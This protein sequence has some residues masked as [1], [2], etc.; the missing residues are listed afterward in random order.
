[1]NRFC[2]AVNLTLRIACVGDSL[3][4]GDGLHE[5]PPKHRVPWSGLRPAQRQLRE[6][7]NYP[8]M[9][10][11]M[12]A[13]RRA[14]VRNY[15]H[16]GSTACNYTGGH[17]PP[18]LQTK[19]FAAALRFSPHVVVLML[20]TNDAKTAWWT[21][22][23]C[24][25]WARDRGHGLRVGLTSIIDAFRAAPEPPRLLLLMAPPP[26]LSS[27][28]VFGIDPLLLAEARRV[29][30]KVAAAEQRR[31]RL[32]GASML[33]EFAYAAVPR[34][35]LLF[36][37]DALHL[38]A[39]G[40]ALLACLVHAQLRRLIFLPC[41][42]ADPDPGSAPSRDVQPAYV[43]EAK[44]HW[45]ST[46]SGAEASRDNHRRS[47]WDPFCRIVSDPAGVAGMLHSGDEVSD[48]RTPQPPCDTAT[49]FGAPMLHT[50]LACAPSAAAKPQEACQTLAAA[51]DI[52]LRRPPLPAEL[53][54]SAALPAD[55]EAQTALPA[56]VEARA[57]PPPSP[58]PPPPR[59]TFSTAAA[60]A[61]R[62][63]VPPRGEGSAAD[64]SRPAGHAAGE[65]ESRASEMEYGASAPPA[66]EGGRLGLEHTASAL[67][68]LLLLGLMVQRAWRWARRPRRVRHESGPR[69]LAY[70]P[71]RMDDDTA[72]LDKGS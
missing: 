70:L 28:S 48:D 24:A 37:P 51:Y 8:A 35:P 6:R 7:G 60:V 67:L 26:T 50:G 11:H 36:S 14:H 69:G 22:G 58:A 30:H 62:Q 40:S 25:Q 65:T 19:E 18:Y 59:A 72:V 39:D 23:P 13:V 43:D 64:G 1:M 21:A 46:S 49:G 54:S 38:N 16:G 5:H 56:D 17:G 71:L 32:Q 55:L 12:S 15:G 29:V 63:G 68:L 53:A 2:P 27:T 20:G 66:G 47:C 4:R 45:F 33:V 61:A 42:R 9:L 31:S 41:G 57:A 34:T 3:T 44:L 10:S 52:D